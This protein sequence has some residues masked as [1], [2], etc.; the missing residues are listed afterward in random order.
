LRLIRV[1]VK[2]YIGKCFCKLNNALIKY[3]MKW[4]C[5]TASSLY[6]VRVHFNALSPEVLKLLYDLRTKC[7][8]VKS[9]ASN[10]PFVSHGH[11]L[12]GCLSKNLWVDQAGNRWSQMKTR[13]RMLQHLRVHWRWLPTVLVAVC[14]RTLSFN[15][16]TTFQQ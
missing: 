1:R 7:F 16:T 12:N 14:R 13:Q 9:Q 5:T 6:A 4:V 8:L 15:V 10:A 3:T 11:L 2:K